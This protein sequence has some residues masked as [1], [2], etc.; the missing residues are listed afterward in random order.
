MKSFQTKRMGGLRA[1]MAGDNW[2]HLFENSAN[3]SGCEVIKIPSGCRWVSAVRAVPV[4]TPFDFIVMR[5]GK[6][7]YV[8]TKSTL[9]S[10]FAYSEIDRHQLHWLSRC[11]K[12]GHKA[13]YIVNFRALKM[14]V[15]FSVY[16]LAGLGPRKSLKPDQGTQL[17]FDGDRIDLGKLFYEQRTEETQLPGNSHPLE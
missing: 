5:A 16:T 2:E 1:K 3:R 7:I 17:S 12:A 15:F 4:K 9:L 6:S 14:V 13:G 11:A 10:S 8:D